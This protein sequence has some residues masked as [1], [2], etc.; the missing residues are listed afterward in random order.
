MTHFKSIP[1]TILINRFH[2]NI[3]NIYQTNCAYEKQYFKPFVSR[4][5]LRAHAVKKKVLNHPSTHFFLC[6]IFTLNM[7]IHIAI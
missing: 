6:K 2:I 4:R 1:I 7:S 5:I 3:K